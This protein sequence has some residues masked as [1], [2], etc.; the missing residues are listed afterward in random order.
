MISKSKELQILLIS[1]RSALPLVINYL[2]RLFS[3]RD[4]NNP[5]L[6]ELAIVLKTVP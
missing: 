1:G 3:L 6:S 5:S 2:L 4:T